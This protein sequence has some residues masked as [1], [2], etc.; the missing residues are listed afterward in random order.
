MLGMIFW[1]FYIFPSGEPLE[2]PGQPRNSS[3]IDVIDLNSEDNFSTEN[4][5]AEDDPNKLWCICRKPHNNRFMIACDTCSE[6]FHGKCVGINPKKGKEME[7]NG[8][9]WTCPKCLEKNSAL[10]PKK[11]EAKK[12][13]KPHPQ[14]PRIEQTRSLSVSAIV[15]QAAQEIQAQEIQAQAPQEPETLKL[16]FFRCPMCNNPYREKSEVELHIIGTHNMT[17]DMLKTMVTCGAIKIIEETF[18]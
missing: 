8:Q 14:L 9:E 16:R 15:P 17:I 12:S 13:L 4:N 1:T 5:I 3:D 2:F 7:D 6:W 18:Q 11:V 10:F